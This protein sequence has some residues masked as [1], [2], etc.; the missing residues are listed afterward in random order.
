MVTARV[1]QSSAFANPADVRKKAIAAATIVLTKFSSR[2]L[3]RFVRLLT[4]A[5]CRSPVVRAQ[6]APH[7]PSTLRHL[8]GATLSRCAGVDE[9]G[10]SVR[11]DAAR[12]NRLWPAL[13]LLRQ[14]FGEIFR[15]AV[16]G[17][18]DFEADLFQ[19][20]ADGGV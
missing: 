8:S 11:A 9:Q 18:Y 19:S 14:I 5:D 17:R 15:R 13:D 1:G 6:A 7:V 12:L 10:S 16:L 20:F 2:G 4:D 3:G